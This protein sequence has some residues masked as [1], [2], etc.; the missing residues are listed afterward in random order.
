MKRIKNQKL[1]IKNLWKFFFLFFV[2][3]SC[4]LF[5]TSTAHAD[6]AIDNG[7]NFLRS[8]QDESGR[9]NTGFSA[10]SQ[11]SAIAFAANGIDVS[12]VKNPTDSLKDFLLSDIPGDTASAT[13]VE[14]RILAIVAIGEDPTSFGGVNYV[15][16]LESFYNNNQLGD[17]CALNDDIFGLLALIASGPSVNTQI[18]QDTLD[19]LISKQDAA[20]N[21]FSFSAPGCNYYST[22]ADITAAAVQALAYAKITG[23]TNT[24]LDL[25]ITKAGSYLFANQNSD[26]G[27]GY[28]GYS[29]TDTTGWVLISFNALGYKD[30]PQAIKAKEWLISQQSTTDGGFLAFDY[31][32]NAY[33]SNSTT[34]AHAVIALSGKSWILKIF[35]PVA[36]PSPSL[37]PTISPTSMPTPTP[38]STPSST[39]TPTFVTTTNYLTTYNTYSTPATQS[40]ITNITKYLPSAIPEKPVGQSNPQVLSESDNRSETMDKGQLLVKGLD[41]VS[42]PLAF[43]FSLYFVLRFME[44]RFKK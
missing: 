20:D 30:T 29:D 28:Y 6:T 27:F 41:S 40:A 5:L 32:A 39:P 10:P 8:K 9:I 36:T 31:G 24:G 25:S 22:S 23:L 38:T 33:V 19:F 16:K 21:G 17:T 4:F 18:K 11:W 26:G 34:T 35:S 12:T 2:L 7:L 14:N 44:R 43:V 13:D 3:V 1:R 15:E 37:S 42:W